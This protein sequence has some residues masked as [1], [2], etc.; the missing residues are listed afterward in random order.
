M[1]AHKIRCCLC[2]VLMPVTSSSQQATCVNCLKSQ[3]DITEG[4][5]KTV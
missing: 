1:V 2:G 4:I 3:V 5:S